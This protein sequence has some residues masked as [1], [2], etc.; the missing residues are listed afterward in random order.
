MVLALL[1]IPN[2]GTKQPTSNEK[3]IHP[4]QPFDRYPHRR[5]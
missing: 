1:L 5:P 2:K 3:D 4:Y